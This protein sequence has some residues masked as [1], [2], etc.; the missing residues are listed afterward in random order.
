MFSTKIRY[1]SLRFPTSLINYE[2]IKKLAEGN[3]DASM[4][5]GFKGQYVFKPNGIKPDEME[6]A[7]RERKSHWGET[8]QW[9]ENSN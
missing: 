6:L 5:A 7:W 3:L 4:P 2:D 9:K 8:V 1:S